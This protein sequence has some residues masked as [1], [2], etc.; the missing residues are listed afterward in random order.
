M[1]LLFF[2]NTFS[3]E[4][5]TTH[6]MFVIYI[7]LYFDNTC[8]YPVSK[9]TDKLLYKTNTII[10]DINVCH[11]TTCAENHICEQDHSSYKCHP[12]ICF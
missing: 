5:F 4:T 1:L 9:I 2:I 12:G 3:T 7:L 11:P 10:L 6:V 8:S